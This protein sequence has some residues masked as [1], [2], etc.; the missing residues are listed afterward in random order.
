MSWIKVVPVSEIVPDGTY[1][2]AMTPQGNGGTWFWSRYLNGKEQWS[3]KPGIGIRF[4][5]GPA[6]IA[7]ITEHGG[8]ICAVE[9]PADAD[10][11]WKARK[12]PVRSKWKR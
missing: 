7:K 6:L 12:H 8:K 3:S 1:F 9:V 2:L 5:G 10:K 4:V 11:R